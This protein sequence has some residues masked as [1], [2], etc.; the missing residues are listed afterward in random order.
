VRHI[1]I[2]LSFLLLSSP[3]IGQE[4][5]VLFLR[6]VNDNWGWFED[7]NKDKDAKYIGEFKDGFFEDRQPNGQGTITYPNG[8]KYV[9]E[10]KDGFPNGQGTITYPNGNKYVGGLKDGEKNG[11]G[12]FT[13][14]DGERYVGKFKDGKYHGQGTVTSP[15]GL[16]YV[17]G[18][19]DGEKEWSR[20]RNLV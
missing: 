1:L 9:G 7:G 12:T 14:S 15:D 20:N 16:K 3:V 11:Q 10:W 19:K 13:F 8:R 4:T 6:E 18:Y 2:F 17:G 5:G